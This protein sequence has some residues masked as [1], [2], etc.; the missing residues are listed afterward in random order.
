MMRLKLL[1]L[2]FGFLSTFSE[3]TKAD[4]TCKYNDS[5]SYEE[6]LENSPTFQKNI[7]YP[8][9]IGNNYKYFLWDV[10]DNECGGSFTQFCRIHLYSE[11]SK[12]IFIKK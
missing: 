4:Q 10:N 11:N 12:N 7:N 1:I 5:K 2:V 3:I 9:I 6:C 8:I